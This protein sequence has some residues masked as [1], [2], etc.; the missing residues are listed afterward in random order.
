MSYAV[1]KTE[2]IVIRT[3]PSGEANLDVVFL[4]RDL[5]KITARVQAGRKIESKMRMQLARYAHVV[6]D[7]V[8]GRQLWRLTGVAAVGSENVFVNETFLKGWHRAI[9]LAEFLI[10]GEDPHPELFDFFIHLM[11]AS[12]MNIPSEGVELFGVIHVL[13]ALGYWHGETLPPVL[14]REIADVLTSRRKELVRMINDSLEATQIM[15]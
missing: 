12:G 8:H 3:I 10:R 14:N 15:V 11:Q 9:T 5:G 4:T 7:V 2:A 13:T 6:I 1:Y